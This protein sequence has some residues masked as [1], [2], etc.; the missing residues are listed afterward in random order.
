M[1]EAPP[2]SVTKRALLDRYLRGVGSP[3]AGTI[4]RRPP[5]SIAPL[6]AAQEELYRR[7]RRVP[8]IP[9][10]Y[11]ECVNLR[12]LGPLD[13][14]ALERAFNEIIKRHE[15]WRTTFESEPGQPAQIVHPFMHVQLPVVDLQGIP[16]A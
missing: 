12:M 15:A 6:S 10:L 3:A 4:G 9:P 8:G 14:V 1:Q 5:G 13:V 16:E 7:E 11:N 2:L